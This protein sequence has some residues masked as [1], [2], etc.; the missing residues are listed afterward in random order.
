M[1]LIREEMKE[2]EEAVETK[3]Y[4]ETAD[5]LTDLIYV[6]LGMGA[7]IGI[8]MDKAFQ[9]V[10][11]NNMSKL[12][13]TE[14]Y[15]KDTVDYYLK[16]PQLGYSTPTYRQAGDGIKCIVYNKDTGKII[17]PKYYRAVDLSS[18]CK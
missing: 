7:R 16:N 6:I 10:H 8:D 4:V 18:I 2:L 11:E 5:A 12:C 14:I 17:K 9:L 13:E 3:N 1:K 15:A